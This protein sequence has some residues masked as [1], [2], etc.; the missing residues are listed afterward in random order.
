MAHCMKFSRRALLALIPSAGFGG[1]L[2]GKRE[3][4]EV[5]NNVV[6]LGFPYIPKP[7]QGRPVFNGSA[8]V[9]EVDTDPTLVVNQKQVYHRQEDGS[10]VPIGQP[11]TISAGGVFTVNGSPAKIV[12]NG[13]YSL[14]VLDK[15][16]SQVYYDPDRFDGVP[17]TTETGARSYK[18]VDPAAGGT[19]YG[20]VGSTDGQQISVPGYYEGSEKGGGDFKWDAPSTDADD[21]GKTFLPTGHS[22]PGRTKRTN[23]RSILTLDDFGCKGNGL[24]DDADRIQKAVDCAATDGLELVV[25]I[26]NYGMAST[27]EKPIGLKMR[28]LSPWFS[29]FSSLAGGQYY[30]NT[31]TLV[32]GNAGGF[33][34][35]LNIDPAS[36]TT[37]IEAYPNQKSGGIENIYIDGTATSGIDGFYFAG[38]HYFRC[39]QCAVTGTA[40][41][42]PNL[43]TDGLDIQHIH[44]MGGRSS[45]SKYLVYLPGLG[46]GYSINHIA[47]GYTGV[48]TGQ[49]LGL[50]LGACRGGFVKNLVNGW[51][52]FVSTGDGVT[53]SNGHFET[54]GID[55]DSSDVTVID[56]QF[57]T[58][59]DNLT[60]GR[61]GINIKNDQADTTSSRRL[62]VVANNEFIRMPNKRGG[63][64]TVD[65]PDINIEGNPSSVILM[66]NIRSTSIS[67]LVS[68]QQKSAALI[69]F[70]GAIVNDW[71]NYAHVLYRENVQ[72]AQ[73]HV[74]VNGTVQRVNTFGG[75]F[76]ATPTT[77]NFS[78]QNWTFGGA[79][80]T[81]YYAIQ[82]M[83]DPVRL[84]GRDG[85]TIAEASIALT[86]GG[87]IPVLQVDGGSMKS[88]GN[89]MYRVYRG[90][91]T[92]SY[93]KYVDIPAANMWRLYD[94]GDAVN[95]WPWESRA[96]GPV[97]TL[98]TG[99]HAGIARY[100]EGLLDLKSNSLNSSPTV[101]TWKQGDNVERIDLTA[102]AI[103]STV[104]T[105]MK[106][107]SSGSGHVDGTDWMRVVMERG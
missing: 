43:Y 40:I 25:P 76:S 36:P 87:N 9:G 77:K 38:S 98:N 94:G 23:M 81:Y 102:P 58:E 104:I 92:G 80:A 11:I 35:Y 39:I 6:S 89:V 8:Y 67:G 93:D 106:R 95:G 17:L 59:D 18:A 41:E 70:D 49:T 50:Y 22:G 60:D 14:A 97:D 20:F 32:A 5:G 3:G 7:D 96:A 64:P 99:G 24:D 47:S 44:G 51:N 78:S 37:W 86:N 90:T 88:A 29:R 27:V 71:K 26:G 61:Y 79:T 10:D 33:L 91:S 74:P 63:W 15:Q 12:V 57:F 52:S 69:G 46:D 48:E 65:K 4:A 100:T 30:D 28:G 56:N 68:E 42:K 19:L 72:F 34:F 83:T 21:G 13:G 53:V 103:G 1:W 107:L 105:G 85:T 2:L 31:G 101:G 16:G 82:A 73:N 66:N 84:L 55:I 54:G 45:D 62:V 75:W